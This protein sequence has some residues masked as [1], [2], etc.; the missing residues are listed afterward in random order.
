MTDSSLVLISSESRHFLSRL[1]Q[2]GPARDSVVQVPFGSIVKVEIPP[3][4]G[5]FSRLIKG[6]TF[7]VEIRRADVEDS[8]RIEADESARGFFDSLSRQTGGKP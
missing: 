3:R 4:A 1:I 6:P 5:W 2:Q 7:T 8:L